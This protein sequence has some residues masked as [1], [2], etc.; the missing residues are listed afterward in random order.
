MLLIIIF[1]IRKFDCIIIR[2]TIPDARDGN[3]NIYN[4]SLIIIDRRLLFSRLKF[5]IIFAKIN[6]YHISSYPP[7]MAKQNVTFFPHSSHTHLDF[8][9][10]SFT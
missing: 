9:K 10:F 1:D 3:I 7:F 4:R 5:K 8:F 2:D 6:I